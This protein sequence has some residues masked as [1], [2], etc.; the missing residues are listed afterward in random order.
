[1][2]TRART[3]QRPM[4]RKT[5]SKTAWVDETE[6]IVSFNPRHNYDMRLFE[7]NEEMLRYVVKL[8]ST[9]YKIT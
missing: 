1:M 4:R 6:K 9:G 8:G 7:T 3:K 2:E 5:N